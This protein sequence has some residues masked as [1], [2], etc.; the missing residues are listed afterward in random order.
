MRTRLV[1]STGTRRSGGSRLGRAGTRRT[2]FIKGP[3]SLDDFVQ[4]MAMVLVTKKLDDVLYSNAKAVQQMAK[5][6]IFLCMGLG[7]KAAAGEGTCIK[8]G[9]HKPG[10]LV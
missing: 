4:K 8:Q 10:C 9:I 2:G 6:F 1:R 7:Q 3:G 5:D